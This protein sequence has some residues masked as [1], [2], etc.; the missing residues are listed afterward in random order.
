M[1]LGLKLIFR[2]GKCKIYKHLI[3]RITKKI[4]T[5][6]YPLGFEAYYIC[7]LKYRPVKCIY[8]G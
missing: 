1:E 6:V 2:N 5:E 3:A 4:R 7:E 8:R